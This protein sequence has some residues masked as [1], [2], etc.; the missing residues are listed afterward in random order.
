[1]RE[2]S[3]QDVCLSRLEGQIRVDCVEE[4]GLEASGQ[5]AQGVAI[6]VD[7]GLVVLSGRNRCPNAANL[8][9]FPEVLGDGC[10]VE[11]IAGTAGTAQSQSVELQDALEVRKQHLHLLPLIA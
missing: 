7:Y 10:E 4:V 9:Q 8:G 2:P 11:L 6:E 3:T 5:F 1:M